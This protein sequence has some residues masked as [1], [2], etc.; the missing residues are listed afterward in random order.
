MKYGAAE[1]R[2]RFEKPRVEKHF[3]T[4]FSS[5]KAANHGP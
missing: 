5:K 2:A 4:T 1:S 3:E